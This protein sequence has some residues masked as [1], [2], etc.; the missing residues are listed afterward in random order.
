[1]VPTFVTLPSLPQFAPMAL[2]SV[3]YDQLSDQEKTWAWF[4]DTGTTHIWTAV[5]QEPL[6]GASMKEMVKENPP[7]T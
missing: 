1:M 6:S 4:I 7:R 5:A 3:L 2:Y